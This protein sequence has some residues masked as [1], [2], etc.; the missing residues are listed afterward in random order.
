MGLH[1]NQMFR[2]FVKMTLTRVIYCDWVESSQHRFS[3]WF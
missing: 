3:R 1:V 2:I